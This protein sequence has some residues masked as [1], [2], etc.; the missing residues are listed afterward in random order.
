[1]NRKTRTTLIQL[2]G[3]LL[4]LVCA[5]AGI[6]W[7]IGSTENTSVNDSGT[8]V[9]SVENGTEDNDTGYDPLLYIEYVAPD[10]QTNEQKSYDYYESAKNYNMASALRRDGYRISSSSYDK[11][12]HKVGIIS[13]NIS[14]PN[15]LSQVK[16]TVD[17]PVVTQIYSGNRTVN[18]SVSEDCPVLVPYYG[19]VIYRADG[20]SRLLDSN[21]NVLMS[22]F[23]GY[24]PAY[25]TDYCGN[26]LFIKGDKYYFW[27]DGKNYDATVYTDVD[28]DT[29]SKLPAA[30]PEAYKYFGYDVE[31]LHNLF[32]TNDFNKEANMT[33]IAYMLPSYAGMVE[34]AVSEEQLTDLRVPS[35]AYHKNSGKLFRFPSYT[36]TKKEEKKIDDKPYYSYKVT[37][38]LWGY[39]DAKGNVV[40][41]PR[42]K[43]AYNYSEDG[44]AVVEDKYGHL[45][46]LNEWGSIVYNYFDNT[47][48]FPELG[49]MYSRDGHY[50][51][52]TFGTENT[53][54]L[55]FDQG[56]VRMRRKL[57]DIENGYIDK[58]DYS[59]LVDTEGNTLNIPA[60]CSIEGYSD[61]VMLIKHGDRYGYMKTDGSWLVE[62]TLSY[63]K[64]FS[65]G[66]AVMGYSKNAQGVIDTE[67]NLILYPM[68]S[69]IESCSGGVITAFSE[70]G[71]WSVFNKMSQNTEKD[72][73][74][75]IIALKERAIAEARDKYY[76]KKEES[77]E[78]K[79]EIEK[80]ELPGGQS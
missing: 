29:F 67:G 55:W 56:Y 24:T 76:N 59:T 8:D 11:S 50:L 73:V 49:I 52:D 32:V 33:G 19:F 44:F 53:G 75:P 51:P 62:P 3:L 4:C 74:N 79:G 77:E 28:N 36:F 69:H 37:E 57:V 38:V 7:H 21:L 30:A 66:L 39:M 48:A 27:Y 5:C 22:N 12:E 35:A 17:K 41:E 16:R 18:E 78:I 64:P 40:V 47:Y 80:N 54:M 10:T 60:G 42:Y 65:E 70:V 43:K 71:G 45:C 68:Y 63:A 6:F 46:V 14:F 58:R 13:S 26:P 61:G 34:F 1:M 20:V 72:V 23:S 31:I 15:E 25:M 2:A 9:D